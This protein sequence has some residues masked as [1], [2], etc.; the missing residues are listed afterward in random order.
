[1]NNNQTTNL[2]NQLAHFGLNPTQWNISRISK[3]KFIIRNTEDRNYSYLG[4]VDQK[5]QKQKWG[6]LTLLS[7]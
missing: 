5:K 1:M 2:L 7:L 3:D 4:K 6:Q